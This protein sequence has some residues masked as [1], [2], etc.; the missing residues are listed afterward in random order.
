MHLLNMLQ[1][2]T[3]DTSNNNKITF[4]TFK[5]LNAQFLRIFF[6]I[7]FLTSAPMD[8]LFSVF[9]TIIKWFS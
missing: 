7:I 6:K 1:Q 9:V 2:E 5:I 8:A 4:Y 3:K